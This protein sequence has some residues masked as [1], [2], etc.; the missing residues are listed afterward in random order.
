M[1][2]KAIEPEI[3]ELIAARQFD[4]LREQLIELEPADV[5]EIIE[6][7]AAGDQAVVFRLMPRDF[8]SDI[9][10]CLPLEDQEDLIRN[11]SMETVGEILNAMS[12][13]DRTRLLEELPGAMAQR[14]LKTLNPEELRIARTLLG[15]PEESIGRLMTPEYVVARLEWT[16]Q[17][18]IEKLRQ[19]G[20][21]AETISY[22]YIVDDQ[23]LLIDDLP[24]GRLVMAE[25]ETLLAD[26]A[27]RNFVAL[28]AMDDRE[29]TVPTF[30]KYDRTALPVVDSTGVLLGIVTVDDVLDVE[31]DEATED[32]QKFGGQASLED[33][34]FATT[35]LTLI[36][37]RAPWLVIL[38]MGAF[39]TSRMMQFY[40][41][42]LREFVIVSLFIPLMISSGGNSGTQS[43][44]L[45][46]R[47]LATN[48]I[49]LKDWSRVLFREI[50]VGLTLGCFLGIILVLLMLLGVI[51][52]DPRFAVVAFIGVMSIVLMGTLLG[53]LMPFLFH[54]LG[55]DPAVASGPFIATFVDLAGIVLYLTLA[56][57]ILRM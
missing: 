7:L 40:E 8:A 15:Y 44:A 55:F 3:G 6:D 4:T 2:G 48:E 19:T 11:L 30:Q 37:K 23:G 27:D 20:A 56:L 31:E 14:L 1:L 16:V 17:E 18:T 12:P 47:S 49:G 36:R 35:R 22:I 9:F 33:S 21:E 26:L 45:I 10:E 52:R 13:D 57:F 41:D 51:E 39:L 54:R 43:A 5:A 50:V 34:Y 32:V 28:S 25:P 42:L 38:F 29:Q 46:I 24:L 53:G